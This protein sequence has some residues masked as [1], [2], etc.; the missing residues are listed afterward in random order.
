MV[1]CFYCDDAVEKGDGYKIHVANKHDKH[2]QHLEHLHL[3]WK[4][5]FDLKHSNT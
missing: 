3:Q 2:L 4:K 1:A 5:K